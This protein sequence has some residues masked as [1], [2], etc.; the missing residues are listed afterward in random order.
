[1]AQVDIYVPVYMEGEPGTR[2]AG[3]KAY[4]F[5]KVNATVTHARVPEGALCINSRAITVTPPAD[6]QPE[7]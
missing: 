5:A 6:N 3:K 1:M 2:N 7:E 4:Q